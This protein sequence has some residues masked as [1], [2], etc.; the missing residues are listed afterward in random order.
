MVGQVWKLARRVTDN[1]QCSGWAAVQEMMTMYNL[2]ALCIL[3]HPSGMIQVNFF[4]LGVGNNH[5]DS[6]SHPCYIPHTFP[7]S[8]PPSCSLP[9]AANELQRLF[10]FPRGVTAREGLTA[11]PHGHPSHPAPPLQLQMFELRHSK[12]TTASTAKTALPPPSAPHRRTQQQQQRQQ[13]RPP[14]QQQQP[15]QGQRHVGKDEGMGGGREAARV[16][17]LPM[18][19]E[20]E[21]AGMEEARGWGWRPEAG[22]AGYGEDESTREWLSAVRRGV[23]LWLQVR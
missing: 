6:V 14:P 18:E 23:L 20:E 17:G 5:L 10:K 11:V 22:V 4:F 3:S 19:D 21:E 16:G 8:F 12:S 7:P 13:Q 9:E 1:N 2:H 15:Q